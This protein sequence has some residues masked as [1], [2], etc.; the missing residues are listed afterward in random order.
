MEPQFRTAASRAA[1]QDGGGAFGSTLMST[2]SE[3]RGVGSLR[4]ISLALAM[5]LF[6]TMATLPSNVAICVERQFTCRTVP[7]MPPSTQSRS[8]TA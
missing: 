4:L 3:R 5:M 8:P 6:G 2:L 7:S 1:V